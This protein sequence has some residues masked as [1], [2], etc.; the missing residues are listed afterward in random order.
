MQNVQR[1]ARGACSGRRRAVLA[2]AGWPLAALLAVLPAVVVLSAAGAAA[3]ADPP[4]VYFFWGQGCPYCERESAFLAQLAVRYPQ[5]RIEAY[6]V[7]YDAANRALM[8]AMLQERNVASQGSV[9]VTIIGDRV[10]IGFNDATAM[11]IE[12]AVRDALRAGG[13]QAS[14]GANPPA[15]AEAAQPAEAGSGT[16]PKPGSRAGSASEP[17]DGAG[18][19]TQPS[20]PGAAG[21]GAGEEALFLDVP[22][23]GRVDLAGRGLVLSTV[24]LGFVDGM[25]PCSLWV[26]SILLALVLHSRSRKKVVVVGVTFLAVAAAVYGAFMV[27]LFSALQLIGYTTWLRI[28]VAAVTLLMALVNIK[29]F[30]A[31]RRGVSLTISDKAKPGLYA[32]MRGILSSDRYAKTIALTAALSAGVSLLE[33]PCTAGFPVIW[34]NLV[35]SAGVRGPAYA[36]LLALYLFVFVIDELAVFLVVTATMQ[37]RR[38]TQGEGRSLK[39]LAGVLMLYLSVVLL[40]QPAVM[41]DVA[42]ALWVFAAALATAALVWLLDRR[43]RRA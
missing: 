26:L 2:H 33:L 36:L 34:T 19:C 37:A 43:R 13:G 28:A 25:N 24:L 23:L 9:P 10:W 21:C 15:P 17:G 22:L 6:E 16:P 7:W 29:D 32:R 12:L 30:V 27:G 41:Q 39:L 11:A 14:A 1:R 18:A 3:A 38:L 5:V 35:A 31:F 40:V 20:D 4:T 8:F 42:G